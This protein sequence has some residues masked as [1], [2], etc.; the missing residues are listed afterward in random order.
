MAAAPASRARLPLVIGLDIGGSKISAGLVS[1]AGEICRVISDATPATADSVLDSARQLCQRLRHESESESDIRAIGVGSAGIINSDAGQ[2]AYANDNLPGW[3][4]TDLTALAHG[5]MPV[6]AE[7]DARALAYG[8]A[9][10]GAGKDYRSLLCVTVGTG[11]GGGIVIDGQLWHGAAYCAGEIGYL[12][13]GWEHDKPQILDQFASG[14]AIERAWRD[15]AS[16]PQP[17]PLTEISRMARA[18]DALA[19]RIIKEK[20]RQF[21]R[22]PGWHRGRAESGSHRDRR[23]RAGNRRIVARRLRSRLSRFC[24]ASPAPYAT[25]AR[26]AWRRRGSARRSH[27]CLARGRRMSAEAFLAAVKG[28][29]IVSCQAL[30]DEPLHGASVMAKMALA[31]QIGGAAAI[32]ANSPADIRA[33][34]EAVD[35]PII[36]LNKRGDSGCLHHADIRRCRSP[37]GSRRGCHRPRLHRPSPARRR[38]HARSRGADSR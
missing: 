6:V 15:A 1:R 8:E 10:L 31:A 32:R 35:L 11:I 16:S 30:P 38:R 27:A 7:N 14:P 28:K 9:I 13:V 25:L 26:P 36:G 33:I 5:D 24:R 20:A 29:L 18:G 2:V 3:S 37:G 4:G 17:L 19:A 12:V 21:W 23:R 22:H 34:K